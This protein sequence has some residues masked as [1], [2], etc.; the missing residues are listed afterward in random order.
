M[1]ADFSWGILPEKALMSREEAES[2]GIVEKRAN[3]R[4]PAGKEN[5]TD[6]AGLSSHKFIEYPVNFI[7][8]QHLLFKSRLPDRLIGLKSLLCE[9]SSP[10]ISDVGNQRRCQGKA[11]FQVGRTSLLVGRDAPDA[12]FP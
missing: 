1:A 7:F 8:R 10:I 5:N 4:R 12:F 3:K 11:L 9:R 6:V 2:Q